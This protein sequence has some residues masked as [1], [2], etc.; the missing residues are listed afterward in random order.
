MMRYMVRGLSI[1]ILAL[2]LLPGFGKEAVFECSFASGKWQAADFVGVKSSRWENIG[3]FKQ[4]KDHIF[5]ICPADAQPDEML[6][7]RAPETYAAMICKT[8]LSGNHTIVATMSFD[9]RMAPSIV[10]AEKTGLSSGGYPEF[11]T[12]YEIVLY[13]QG[14]NVWRHWFKDGKQVW[15]KVGFLKADFKPNTPYKLEVNIAFSARGPVWTVSAG[16]HCFG[17]IDDLLMSKEYY[18]GIVAAEGVNRFYDFKIE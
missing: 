17:F 8:P 9:H 4:E 10:I 7:K 18:A 2:T 12:H 3:G 1:A 5:N 15:R 11:R 16:G 6:S 13:D 14:L